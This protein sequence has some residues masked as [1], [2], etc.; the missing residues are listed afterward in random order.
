MP[1]KVDA[2]IDQISSFDKTKNSSNLKQRENYVAIKNEVMSNNKTSTFFAQQGEEINIDIAELNGI[3]AL[4]SLIVRIVSDL[5]ILF[6][7][8][9]EICS[10]SNL[11]RLMT[12]TSL[13]RFQQAAS[14]WTYLFRSL[15]PN[16]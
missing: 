4:N 16:Q 5:R 14:A 12:P 10:R 13:H 3:L 1:I 15:V 6:P 7:Q 8:P 2:A 9:F 11:L